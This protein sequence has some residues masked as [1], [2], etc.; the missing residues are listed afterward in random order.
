MNF[1]NEDKEKII[2][3]HNDKKTVREIVKIIAPEGK[4]T[5]EFWQAVYK[6]I[7]D[8]HRDI[9]I[10]SSKNNNLHKGAYELYLEIKKLKEKGLTYEQT[11]EELN[12]RGEKVSMQTVKNMYIKIYK[13]N[14]KIPT[15]YEKKE[16]KIDLNTM[17]YFLREKGYDP[18]ETQKLLEQKGIEISTGEIR[19]RCTLEYRNRRKQPKEKNLDER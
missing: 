4:G 3:L 18:T 5:V 2:Q 14:N 7:E 19:R 8:Y 13:N 16:G 6:V 1:S 9:K 15:I 10:K 12:K 17:I 11:T